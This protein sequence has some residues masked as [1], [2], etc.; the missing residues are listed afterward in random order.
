MKWLKALCGVVAFFLV[1]ILSTSLTIRLSLKDAP[2]VPC[3]DLAGL[4][5]EDAKRAGEEAGLGVIATKWEIKKDVPYSRV[6]AQVPDASVSVREGRTISVILS[7]GPKP[8]TIPQLVGLS[9]EEAQGELEARGMPL[10]KILYVPN[11]AVGTVMAQSPAAGTGI[12]GEGGMVLVAG[13]REKRFF[14][15]PEITP[16]DVASILE[17]LDKKE[18][19]Y[20]LTPVGLPDVIREMGPKATRMI[21]R[22]VFSGDAAI[23]LP[24]G[25]AG[26]GL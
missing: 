9:I 22:I 7:D 23:E 12:L 8:T 21:P 5:Y 25:S 13:G 17:E 24:A 16:N 14:V 10:K 18:I 15:M 4:D 19:K 6:L 2:I 11:T 26:G 3:P 20:N 1:L